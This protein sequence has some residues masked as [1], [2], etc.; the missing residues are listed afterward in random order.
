M[1]KFK[2]EFSLLT[3]YFLTFLGVSYLYYL[4]FI[5]FVIFYSPLFMLY[6]LVRLISVA[7]YWY[8]AASYW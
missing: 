6:V 4:W 2:S 3:E 7:G 5:I 1:A 8:L